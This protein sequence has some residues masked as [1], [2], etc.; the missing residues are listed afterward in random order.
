[1]PII[2][3]IFLAAVPITGIEIDL[4]ILEQ[5]VYPLGTVVCCFIILGMMFY[6]FSE[7]AY[8]KPITQNI[9]GEEIAY[10]K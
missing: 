5:A 9:M 7:I 6:H 2:L 10:G 3:F 4:I 8:K 1:M